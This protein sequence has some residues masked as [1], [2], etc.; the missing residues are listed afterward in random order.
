MATLAFVLGHAAVR[1]LTFA[2]PYAEY[3]PGDQLRYLSWIRE[4]G[5]HLLIA[6]P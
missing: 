2:G 6:D 4:A 5:L 1:G 3:V